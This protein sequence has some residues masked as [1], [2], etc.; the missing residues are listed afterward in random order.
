MDTIWLTTEHRSA[1]NLLI[2]F[3]LTDQDLLIGTMTREKSIS[4]LY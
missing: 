1:L 3:N 4:K 2:E